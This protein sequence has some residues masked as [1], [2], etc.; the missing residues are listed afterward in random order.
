METPKYPL[1]ADPRIAGSFRNFLTKTWRSLGFTDPSLLQMDMAE[2]MQYGGDRIVTMAFRGAAK[3]YIAI[4]FCLWCLYRDNQLKVLNTSATGRF[5]SSNAAFAWKMV[6]TFDWLSHMRP[7]NDQKQSALEFDVAGARPSKDASFSSE[8]IFG[9]LTGRRADVILADDVEVPNTSSTEGAREDLRTRI[10]EFSA[11]IKPGGKILFL[12]T[13]Q[14]EE[15]VYLEREAAGFSIRI[16][17]ILYPGTDAKG[18]DE[19]LRYGHRLAPSIAKAVRDNPM[20]AHTSTEPGRFD[21]ADIAQRQMEWGNTEFDRQ[22]RMFLDAG[23][24]TD[25]PLR[26]RDLMVMDIAPPSEASPLKLPAVTQW[27]TLKDQLVGG[28][29]VDGLTGDSSLYAPVIP[30]ND[31]V[32]GPVWVQP[33]SVFMWVDPSGKGEDETCWTIS[34]MLRGKVFVLW[35]GAD[36][37]GTSAPV[38]ERIA[39]DAKTWGVNKIEIESNFGQEMMGNLLQPLLKDIGHPCS[40]EAV[41]AGRMQKEVRIISA[42]EPVM[43]TH[44]LILNAEILRQDFNI[45]YPEIE[46]AKRRFY[47]L[48]YQL[49][50]LTRTKDCIA[51]DDRVESIAR[52]VGYYSEALRKSTKDA[53]QQVKDDAMQAEVDKLIETRIKQGLYVP[54]TSALLTRKS[55]GN[56]LKSLLFGK[57]GPRR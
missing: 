42:L 32:G 16:W 23:K 31:Q 55:V 29:Q 3:T 36:L 51:K 38:L 47:R 15:T 41:P 10:R 37:R 56:R 54:E 44:R 43:T 49:T 34:A 8:G 40:V 39:K 11:I 48:T 19:S 4:P 14:H 27:L 1:G 45:A 17:P 24:S 13:A 52:A 18:N 33:D 21:E 53:E 5:S 25:R 26:L 35:Q 20:L 28:I 22:F 2:W 30:T 6:S 7:S 12:G 57:R 9:Q 50:R 46:D